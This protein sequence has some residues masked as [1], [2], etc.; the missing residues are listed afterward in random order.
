MR[1]ANEYKCRIIGPNCMGVYDPRNVDTMFIG[2]RGL[3][4]PKLGPVGLFSQSGALGTALLN[5]VFTCHF[6]HLSCPV[7]L[8]KTG[9]PALFRSVTRAMWT[10]RTVSTTSS[11]ILL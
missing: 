5:E 9:F 4:K 6:L 1:L 8:K 10:K 2:D 3:S 11:T 7:R